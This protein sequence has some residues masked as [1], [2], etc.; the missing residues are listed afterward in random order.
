MATRNSLGALN[1][2]RVMIWVWWILSKNIWES[3]YL[4]LV[5]PCH[6]RL[7]ALLL[8]RT[9][10]LQDHL[11]RAGV[12][13]PLSW[14]WAGLWLTLNRRVGQKGQCV[15]SKPRP[16]PWES[17]RLVC[18]RTRG[19]VEDSPRAPDCSLPRHASRATSPLASGHRGTREPSKGRK[20][21]PRERSLS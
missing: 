8:P 7:I 3:H 11:A 21:R 4:C 10:S 13:F 1:D 14:I 2:Y 20:D 19:H 9:V 17:P 12:S 6:D 15:D 18:W 16:L 5:N